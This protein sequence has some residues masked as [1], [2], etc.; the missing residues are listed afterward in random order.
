MTLD[1]QQT[2]LTSDE[3]DRFEQ[4]GLVVIDRPCPLQLIDSVL[5]DIEPVLRDPSHPWKNGGEGGVLFTRYESRFKDYH[6]NR[7]ANAWVFS[8]PVRKLALHPTIL[9]MIEEL[10]A[11]KPL[12]YQT[13]N[14]PVGTEQAVHFDAMAFESDPPGL[15]C[16]VWVALEDMDMDNGPLVYYPGSQRLASSSVEEVERLVGP[17]ERRENFSSHPEYA[18]RRWAQHAEFCQRLIKLHGLEPHYATVRKGQAVIWAANILHGGSMVRDVNRTRHSQVTHYFFEGAYR[19][20]TPTRTEGEHIY[21]NYPSWIRDP[22]PEYSINLVHETIREHVPPGAKLLIT[23]SD[24]EGF[25]EI[26]GFEAVQFPGVFAVWRSDPTGM[27]RAKELE[28]MREKGAQF[29]VFPRSELGG[30]QN[31][32]PHLQSHLENRYRGLL[33]DGYVC[34]IYQLDR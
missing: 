12:P 24:D 3:L 22:L 6:W 5:N 16:G 17:L 25:L 18:N 32:F 29:I 20:Y 11:A 31:N 15:M 4:D 28:R 26:D 9:S 14:F 30:L 34:A 19:T 13:L 2:V 7:I 23:I 21:W 10:Y 33:R 27:E 1:T 8:E